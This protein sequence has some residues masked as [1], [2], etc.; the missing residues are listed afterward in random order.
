MPQLSVHDNFVYSYSV[1]C[2]RQRI[3][4]HTAFRD[5]EPREFIDVVFHDVVAHHFQH[6]LPNNILFDIEEVEVSALIRDNASVFADS[7]RY[8]WPAV[9]YRGDLDALV[10]RLKAASLQAYSINSSYGMSGWVLAG[11]CEYRS[12]DTAATGE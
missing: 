6:V 3:V 9:E 10:E 2:Q 1:N 7:W 11:K 5:R 12:R 4:L 8:A